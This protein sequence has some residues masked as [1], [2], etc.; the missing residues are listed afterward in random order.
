[1]LSPKNIARI[2]NSQFSQ[3][4]RLGHVIVLNMCLIGGDFQDIVIIV[5]QLKSSLS[6]VSKNTIRDGGLALRY[7]LL[8]LFTQFI[9][10]ILLK[11]FITVCT[12]Y[13]IQLAIHCL[14]SSRYAYIYIVRDG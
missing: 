2:E 11:L 9:L 3:S 4:Y 13:D 5:F 8:T 6:Y 14:E 1:M 7:T 12:V 10:F